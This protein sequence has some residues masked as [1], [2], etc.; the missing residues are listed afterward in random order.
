MIIYAGKKN[1]PLHHIALK[2]KKSKELKIEKRK[3]KGCLNVLFPKA[4]VEIRV[5]V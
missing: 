4:D 2:K 3:Q 1:R 5:R